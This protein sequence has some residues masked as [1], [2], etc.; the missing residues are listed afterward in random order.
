[1]SVSSTRPSASWMF[2]AA[3]TEKGAALARV[4]EL[5]DLSGLGD[6]EL[7]ESLAERFALHPVSHWQERF[8]EGS[9]AVVPL[10]SLSINREAGL[11]LESEGPA[12]IRQATYRAIR[13]DRHPMRRWVDLVAPNAVRPDHAT[14]TI[15][16]AAPKPGAQ[17]RA[18]LSHLGHSEAEIATMIEAGVAG[19][20][21]SLRYLPE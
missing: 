5:E 3:P 12:D 9:S 17:T 20:G 11:H 7:I 18:I 19:E 1:M 21:W 14:I 6:V 10:G 16:A 13:H 8:I 4:P 15:P 2:F